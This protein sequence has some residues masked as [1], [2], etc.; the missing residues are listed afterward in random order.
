MRWSP[1]EQNAHLPA[2]PV[3]DPALRPDPLRYTGIYERPGTRYE[4]TADGWA[5][6]SLG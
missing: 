4:V 3:P 1:P 5:T 2:L 6:R